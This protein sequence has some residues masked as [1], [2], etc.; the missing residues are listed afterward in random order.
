MQQYTTVS[1]PFEASVSRVMVVQPEARR[2]QFCRRSAAG[3]VMR[4]RMTS[5]KSL[6]L[7]QVNNSCFLGS[8]SKSNLASTGQC[9]EE[10][11]RLF[12]VSGGWSLVVWMQEWIGKKICLLRVIFKSVSTFAYQFQKRLFSQLNVVHCCLESNHYA[13]SL[14]MVQSMA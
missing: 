4:M 9:I 13:Y 2:I 6:K 7:D 8:K 14:R 12:W 3:A 1:L 11:L 10:A 5:H